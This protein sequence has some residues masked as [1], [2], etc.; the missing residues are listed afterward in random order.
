MP[1]FSFNKASYEE[2]LVDVLQNQFFDL[3][4]RNK[5]LAKWAGGRL[6]LTGAALYMYVK[7]V[8]L[9][10]IKL[11]NE[12]VMVERILADFKEAGIPMTGE[13]VYQKMRS[14]E[15]RIKNK[16]AMENKDAN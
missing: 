12:R 7:K 1:M 8:I 16:A 2:K 6:G 3:A 10:Y 4:R 13:I 11:P 15:T 5:I 14:V 9:G